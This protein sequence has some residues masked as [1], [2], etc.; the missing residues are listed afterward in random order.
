MSDLDIVRRLAL[1]E[2]RLEKL[3]ASGTGYETGTWT[4]SL[5]GLTIAG[6]FTYDTTNTGGAWTRI[7]DRVFFC[8]RCRITAAS[9][10][11]TGALTI[12][13]LPYTS[14]SSSFSAGNILGGAHFGIW[15]GVTLTAGFTQ[16]GGDV[17]GS[18]SIIRLLQSGSGV[19]S[20]AIQGSQWALIAGVSDW[21]FAG[22][23]KV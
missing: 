7:G 23:Y 15:T 1:L 6:T 4:P 5:V 13:G 11:P 10:N 12:Q 3:E 2:R 22:H 21:R 20:V 14:A 19:G 9:V 18:E 8:G 17:T 16:L